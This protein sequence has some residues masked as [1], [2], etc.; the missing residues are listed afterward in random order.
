MENSEEPIVVKKKRGRKP[1]S[2]TSNLIPIEEVVP[3][4]P[5]K[6]GRKPKGGKLTNKI[7]INSNEIRV[8]M[9]VILHLNC[10]NQDLYNSD[11]S[12]LMDYDPAVPPIVEAYKDNK[13]DEQYIFNKEN[14]I[15]ENL[16]NDKMQSNGICQ[17]CLNKTT[18]NSSNDD[19]IKIKDINQKIKSLKIQL[20]K[21]ENTNIKAACFWC[22]YEFDNPTCYIPK[23]EIDDEIIGYG[24]FC[25]PECAAAFLLQE[26][27][28]DSMKYERYHLL[29]K[30][31]SKIYD[32]KQ[33]IRPAP[34]P[35]YLLDKFFGNLSIQEY[36]K[37][38]KTQ[39]MLLVVDK[40]MSR[41]LPELHDDNEEIILTN[42]T[43]Q[44]GS[45]KVKRAGDNKSLINKND[46]VK[47]HFMIK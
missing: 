5:K 31:Y 36:R 16:D 30:T 11:L 13:Y 25:R 37:L 42:T 41:I 43:S 17:T 39:H 8:E 29:N 28:D 34:N 46:L 26:N 3:H 19:N 2:E 24:S 27:I 44:K 10:N 20:Y 6:R 4:V 22:T 32:F 40:P 21:N 14:A 15:N 18:D 35:H 12:N 1:K 33:N 7:D 45:Y 38:L 9:N 23:H 47:E